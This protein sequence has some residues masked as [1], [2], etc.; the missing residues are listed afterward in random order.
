MADYDVVIAGGGHNA[1]VCAAV[2]CK[3]GLRTLVLDPATL[4]PRTRGEAG[5]LCHFDL[6]NAGSALAV[7]TEDL[8]RIVDDGLELLG[9]ASGAELRGCSL[10]LAE[11]ETRSRV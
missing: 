11:W 4:A 9:R 1:L 7:L 3:A 8:G 10:T 5:V 6:A 2:L